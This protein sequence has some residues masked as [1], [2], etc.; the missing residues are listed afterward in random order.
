MLINTEYRNSEYY[1]D[2]TAAIAIAN[3][4]R[5]SRD[6]ELE[7]KLKRS[8]GI[9][10]VQEPKGGWDPERENWE[11]LAIAMIA[12]MADDYRADRKALQKTP[13]TQKIRRQEIETDLQ[14]IEDFF[15]SDQF[16]VL[17]NVDGEQILKRLKEEAVG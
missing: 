10:R 14:E 16:M 12:Q 17:T 15:L 9:I 3:V 6:E 13:V 11:D 7:R 1:A 8:G 2:P 5:E 4:M